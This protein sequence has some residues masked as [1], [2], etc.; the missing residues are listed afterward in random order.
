MLLDA[1]GGPCAELIEIPALF[2]NADH[3]HIEIAA[4]HHRMQRREDLLVGEVA[5][6]T[7]ENE[8]VR[9]EIIHGISF[10]KRRVYPRPFPGGRRT[11]SASP[12]AAC[13]QSPPHRAN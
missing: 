3:R 11:G 1:V 9:M 6:R 7:E 12:R 5:G 13:Q 10:L 8:G 2:C 4:F